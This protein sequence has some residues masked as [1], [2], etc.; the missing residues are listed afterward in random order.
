MGRR[1]KGDPIHGWIN[2]DK[3]AGLSSTQ[4]MAKVRRFLNA[5]K[6]GHAGTLDPLASGIL[7]IALGEATKTIP[8]A[9]DHLKTYRFTVRWGEARDTDDAEGELTNISNK[10]PTA[11]EIETILPAFTGEIEQVP[12]R[13]SAIK[14]DGQR[15]YDLARDGEEFEPDSR[16]VYIEKIMLLETRQ[17]EAD[18]EC[19]CG[20]GTYVRS[21]GRDMALKLGTYGHISTL[22]R[23]AVG[24]FC[25][26]NAISLDKLEALG[27]IAALEKALLPLE[28]VLDDIPALT[29]RKDETAKLKNGQFLHFISRPDFERLTAAGLGDKETAE[30][31]AIFDGKPVAIVEATGAE[32]RPVRV[33][34]L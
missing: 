4:A 22:R 13:F 14:I 21:L 3:P 2:L 23:T 10:R 29:L 30:A 28:S 20:K 33:L 32:V 9:Q 25:D 16:K 1:Q 34:N 19:V 31:L 17:D 5:R 12:P 18:F 15:A 6:A 26:K 24:P 8:Y 11:A 27:H 7:P